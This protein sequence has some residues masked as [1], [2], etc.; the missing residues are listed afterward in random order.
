MDFLLIFLAALTTQNIVFAYFLGICPYLGV[1]RKLDTALGMGM[2]VT[3]VMT[4]TALF[5][6]PIYYLILVPRNLI[7]LELPVFI[8]VIASLVQFLEMY[9]RKAVPHLYSALGI[10]LPLITTNCAILGVALFMV[11]K[12]YDFIHSLIYAFSTGL[13]FS[14]A[15]LIMAGIRE[16]LDMAPVPEGLKG[17]PIALIIAGLLALSFMGFSGLVKG[18]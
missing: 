15:L 14:L 16:D 5:S 12:K 18:G 2:A 7:Y 10:Y 9:F 4:L 1:S 3:F 13:G 8:L 11:L 17:V 6:W